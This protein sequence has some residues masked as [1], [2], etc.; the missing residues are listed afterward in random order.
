VN[1][2]EIERLVSL[3]FLETDEAQVLLENLQAGTWHAPD[4][5]P[6][7]ELLAPKVATLEVH[8]GLDPASRPSPVLALK[9]LEELLEQDKQREADGFPRK[10]HIGKLVKPNQSGGKVVIVPSTT[11]P[12]FYHDN[13]ITE[14]DEQ[15]TGG[16]G[17]GQEGEV[18][19]EQPAQQQQQGE[20]S[21]SG[22]GQGGEHDMSST[23]YD[24]GKVLT[25][26]FELPH[27]KDKGKKRSFTKFTYDL[28]D[29][30]RGFGQLLDKKATLRRM[31]KSNI[32]LGNITPDTPFDPK[33]LVINPN[34]KIYRIMSQEKDFE[35]QAVVFFLR[36]YSGSMDGDPTE[37]ITTQHLFIYS[38]LMYQY[39]NN[40]VSRFI[41]HD[42]QA[43]EVEDFY[44]YHRYR[45]AG[46]TN[47]YPAF[48][49]VKKI[50]DE[51]QLAKDYN[52]YIFHGTDGDDW[53]S[54]GKRTLEA[55]KAML[56]M[57][58]RV[59][60]TVAKNSWSA[61]RKTT[62]EQYFERSGLLGGKDSK[63]KMDAMLASEAKE[64]RIVEGIKKLLE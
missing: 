60:I 44:T 40:V 62:V 48:E 10:I 20:G 56:P 50:L 31:L 3:N 6:W 28:T 1:L 29:R 9:T 14:D 4:D 27:L 45:V 47:V 8:L 23:A 33:D 2:D 53:E 38:W 7:D 22:Q 64:K 37:V 30:N 52:I 43:R 49:L 46:G 51:E 61:N 34:D 58:N 39:H 35:T 12:K 18:I 32:L 55:I 25:E 11:E 54:H 26:Q 13:S 16:S 15:T 57:V 63:V 5:E 19:A 21:G 36:D 17:E 24:L 59:G 41:L 42:T